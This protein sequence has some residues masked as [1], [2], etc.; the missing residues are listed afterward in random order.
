[1]EEWLEEWRD[2]WKNGRIGGWKNGR[3]GGWMAGRMEGWGDGWKDGWKNGRIGG[4]MDT[5]LVACFGKITG[6]TAG[7]TPS[8]A[9]TATE[10]QL[11]LKL[12]KVSHNSPG[13]M[14]PEGG[15]WEPLQ[16]GGGRGHGWSAPHLLNTSAGAT[17]PSRGSLP[18]PSQRS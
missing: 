8:R 14:E 10:L 4:W 11:L 18:A 13:R 2:G 5:W 12:Q 9:E 17:G 6:L 15:R 16:V 1:M 7:R 3:I